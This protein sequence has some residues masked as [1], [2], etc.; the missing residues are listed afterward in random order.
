MGCGWINAETMPTGHG[1]LLSGHKMRAINAAGYPPYL[2]VTNTAKNEKFENI[3]NSGKVRQD[4]LKDYIQHT[5]GNKTGPLLRQPILLH[6]PTPYNSVH[7][8]T[9][10]SLG[11]VDAACRN[12][13]NYIDHHVM[14]EE[15]PCNQEQEQIISSFVYW[16]NHLKKSG[17]TNKIPAKIHFQPQRGNDQRQWMKE[18]AGSLAQTE[19]IQLANWQHAA[20]MART[21]L[22]DQ[23]GK[24]TNPTYMKGLFEFI[25][26][27][28][29]VQSKFTK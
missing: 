17:K 7:P 5:M 21:N 15:A 9:A 27:L 1:E 20:Q 10:S 16:H 19:A 25:P 4:A 14:Q 13:K 3:S 8:R 2:L 23:Q 22:E 26:I 18:L 29:T 11:T 28:I 6:Q 24:S 12:L